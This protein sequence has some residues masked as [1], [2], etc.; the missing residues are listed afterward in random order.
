MSLELLKVEAEA[1]NSLWTAWATS[2]DC[3]LEATFQSLNY[4]GF[5]SV[6]KYL[7]S[8]GLREKPQPPKLNIMVAGGLRFTL[9]GEANIEAYCNDNT[10]KGKRFHVVLKEKKTVADGPSEVDLKEYNTRIKL[11][12]E[13]EVPMDNEHV[14]RAVSTWNTLPKSFRYIKRFSFESTFHKNIIFDASFVR[15]SKKNERGSYILTSTFQAANL[16]KQPLRYEMEVEASSGATK[17][18]F[19]TGIAYAL[20]GVQRSYVLVRNAVKAS[21]VELMIKQTGAARG[22]FPGSQPITLS[23]ENVSVDLDE[24]VSNIRH[25]DYN[26]TDKADGLRCLMVVGKDGRIFMV[27]RNLNVYGTDRRLDDVGTREWAGAVLDGEWVTQ[28]ADNK[29]MSRYYAF[30]IFNGHKGENVSTRPFI[31]RAETAVSRLAALTE[32]ISALNAAT[33]TIGAIPKHYSLSIQAKSFYTADDPADKQGI[34]NKAAAVLDRL[35]VSAPYHTD[36]L[37]F[38]PNAAP[39]QKGGT[40]YDQFKWKPAN[41]NSVDF[42]VSVEKERGLD[43]KP[44]TTELVATK[45]R[46]DTNQIVRFKTL[47]LFVGSTTDP[48]FADPRDTVLNKK[49]YPSELEKPGGDY[50]PVE[51]APQT[52]PDPMA[53]VC[54]V[55]IDAG[56]T[57]AAGASPAA[58]GV[59]DAMDDTIYCDEVHDPI[60]SKTI[61]E[62]VYDPTKPTGWRWSPMRVRWDKTE[63]YT[64][65]KIIGTLNGESAANNVWSS[66]HDPITVNMIRTGILT[67]ED[68]TE[69]SAVSSTLYYQRKAAQRDQYKVGGMTKFH[70]EYIKDELLLSNVL[71]K[72]SRLIDFSCGQ[73]GD[74]HKWVRARAGMVVGCDIALAGLAE[75]KNGAYRRYLN[76]IIEYKGDV[77]QILFIQADSSMRLSDGSAGMSQLDRSIL[78]TLWGSN[79]MD[80]PVM[81]KEL[82]GAA[83]EGFD[84]G[85]IM[86]ALH[87]F[88]KDRSTLDGLLQ[89][90][91]D[92]IKVGGYFVG[93]CF[94]GDSVAEFLK[95]VPLGGVKRGNEKGLDLWTLTK[96]YEGSVLPA[97]DEGLGYPIGMNFISI[98]ETFTEYL[99]S[100]AYLQTRLAEI[101]LELL[102]TEELATKNLKHSTSMFRESYEMSGRK[103]AMSPIVSQFTFLN[104]WFIFRRRS[105]GA[106]M[107]PP[108]AAAEPIVAEAAAEETEAAATA[109]PIVAAD[110][111]AAAAAAVEEPTVGEEA[112]AEPTAVPAAV[113][114]GP[115]YQFYHKSSPKDELGLKLK[116]WRRV[117]S[118]Y[119]PFEF[120]DPANPAIRYSSLEAALGAAKYQ[121]ATNKP[122]LGAQIFSTTGNI[123]TT[124]AAKKGAVTGF[125]AEA[126][127][128]AFDEAWVFA[129][130][131]GN[132]M[133]DAQKQAT[134]RKTGAKWNQAAWD[135]AVERILT[136]LVRQRFEG[137]EQFS[138]ILNAVKEHKAR[139]AYYVAGGGNE[140]AG[141]IKGDAIEGHNLYGRA[142]MRLVEIPF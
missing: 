133:R 83:R 119:A 81:A 132:E 40:W 139:L 62:M 131:E 18:A 39:L 138:I 58:L 92:T 60:Y 45:L 110:E 78:R 76:K 72:G 30:D 108:P 71:S 21:V 28:D 96:K 6:I 109:E 118:T 32:A 16:H 11:R 67:G 19:L 141:S 9:V 26:V 44:S 25:G 111:T 34:F 120:K 90:I 134:M 33:Y 129:E 54:Y 23:K 140:L 104:R 31:I 8:I 17:A 106:G 125:G 126:K 29:P 43:G 113:P 74:I 68:V 37:I 53:S 66:I 64:R 49:P 59:L 91:A 36:G 97:G 75:P 73:A 114:S 121:V 52:Y 7:R 22:G 127:K 63:M 42:L 69:S 116:H 105:M 50:R 87:Y 98:G 124:I 84:V 100:W 35:E 61:V 41:M 88:F 38:T 46:E 123:H 93:C 14:V 5:L 117:L 115:I 99:V 130:E 82:R 3:E 135:D 65:G 24:K 2:D 103:Y 142:L 101:G 70:N 85:A 136:D 128:L 89:N 122:E 48:A 13:L 27:D 51:F 79:E 57:D 112:A 86:F 20:R 107:A 55:A 56:A 95:D 80:A 102:T 94:D 137:D 77:P 12:R 1:I 4:T 10:I 15:E 47:R